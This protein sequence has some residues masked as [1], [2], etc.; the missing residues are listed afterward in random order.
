MKKIK[1]I[2]TEND[3]GQ[4]TTDISSKGYNLMEQIVEINRVV[5]NRLSIL[6]DIYHKQND[7]KNK[8]KKE[9]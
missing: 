5:Q 8:K 4:T 6:W 2:I 7:A 9:A 3:D 1:I